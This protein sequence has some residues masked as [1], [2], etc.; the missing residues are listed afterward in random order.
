MKNPVFVRGPRGFTIIELMAVV[1]IVG[2]LAVLAI[3]AYRRYVGHSK[4]AEVPTMFL[5]IKAAQEAYKDETFQYASPSSNTEEYYP[6]NDL[7]GKQKMNFAGDENGGAT[8]QKLGVQSSGPVLFVYSCVGG[9]NS[10]PPLGAGITVTNWPTNIAAPWYVVKARA[11]IYGTGTDTVFAS[12]SFTG[13]LFSA[14][15]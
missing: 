3:A 2:I 15:P 14:N 12:G 11:N 6:K 10:A 4:T 7:P 13:E 1:T 8:W 5:S 9:A